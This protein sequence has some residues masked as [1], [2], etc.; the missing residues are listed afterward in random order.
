MC[1]SGDFNAMTFPVLLFHLFLLY[2]ENEVNNN[3]GFLKSVIGLMQ[4]DICMSLFRGLCQPLGKI[5]F[6]FYFPFE[7][8]RLREFMILTHLYVVRNGGELKF[9]IFCF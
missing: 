3:N 6:Y 4:R 1:L 2:V 7:K 8:M 9:T 5:L